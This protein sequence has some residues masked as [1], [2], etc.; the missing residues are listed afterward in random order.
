M[1]NKN[2]TFL[3]TGGCG[4]IG[5]NF[6]HYL[7]KNYNDEFTIINLDKLTYAGNLI[8]LDGVSDKSNYYFVKG[9]ICNRELVE[10]IFDKFKPNYVVNFAAESHVDR[11]IEEP[12]IFIKTNVLG[13]YTLFDVSKEYIKK[14]KIDNFR[15]IQISTDE[16][17]GSLQLDSKE[18]FNEES[19]LK[20]NSPYS[21]SKASAD[22]LAKSF[23]VTYDLPIII[24]RS[25]NNFGPR[26][27][28][29]KLIPLTIKKAL[30]GEQIPVYGDGQN[31]R[32]WIYVEDNC[33]AIDLVIHKGEIGEI[34]NIGGENEWKNIDLVNLICKILSELT[35]KD[36][37]E[38]KKLITFVKDRPGHDKKYSLDISRIK[39]DL[40]WKSSKNFKKNL[41]NTI[42]WYKNDIFVL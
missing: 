21:A 28:P 5:S 11:S 17:Y 29:E 24:T 16:V 15:F 30:K 34:Y 22:L 4:F 42:N 2:R 13:A 31:I 36:A 8:N 41:R 40:E 32:D 7:F 23:F 6:I 3:I 39:K 38:Y 35:G 26:Q 10:Y 25:S 18:K 37:K 12:E 20:P 27:Y 9:D 19:P 33:K 14:N 1:I